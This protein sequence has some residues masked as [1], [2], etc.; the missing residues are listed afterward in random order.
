MWDL[1]T[2]SRGTR[3]PRFWQEAFEAA[4]ENLVSDVP[5]VRDSA[6]SEIAKI[7]IL[8]VN[9]DPVPDQSTVSMLPY[10]PSIDD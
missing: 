2:Q 6:F 3:L 8:T 7:S 9:L 10:L 4:Y 1:Y 5:G